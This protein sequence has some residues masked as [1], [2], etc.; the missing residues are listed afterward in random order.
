[1]PEG[2]TIFRA[3]TAMRRAL[4]GKVVTR[5]ETVLP[6]L[7]RVDEGAPIA[8]RVVD[9]VEAA[10]KHL[11]VRLSGGLVLRT[12]M[13]MNGSWHLYPPGER[14][15]RPRSAMRI[16][17]ATADAV[18]VA[19]DVPIAELLTERQAARQRDLAAL[20]R[21]LL[22][23]GF[24]AAEA[25][26]RIRARGGEPIAEAL[27]DQ[28]VI[29]GIGNVFKSEVLFEAGIHPARAAASLTDAEAGRVVEV[30][31]RQLRANRGSE[32]GTT[33]TSGRRTTRRAA[34]AEALWVYAR[35]GRPCR[36][37]GA[38]IE[39]LRQGLHARGTCFCPRC[40]PSAPVAPTLGP[41]RPGA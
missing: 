23:P 2:D 12:H 16:V 15:R 18:A 26:R 9:G 32:L 38:R 14:W 17:L 27:L 21:D 8:G 28:R 35:G 25:A 34:P 37:C 29:A 5:F 30:A 6:A 20:G 22:A 13:R 11:L 39:T 7:A 41:R 40:Q 33:M 36:R 3:A 31:L 1:V 19:F 10:G 24:D 4:A